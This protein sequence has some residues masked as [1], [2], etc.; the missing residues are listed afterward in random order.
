LQLR[1]AINNGVAVDEIEEVP[2]HATIYCG[3][4]RRP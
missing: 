2:L 3:L 4:S 1:G